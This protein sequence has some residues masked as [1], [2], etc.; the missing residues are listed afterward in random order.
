MQETITYEDALAASTEYFDG[1]EFAAKVFLD[2]YALKDH[3]EGKLLEK[4]PTDMHNRLAKEFARIERKKFKNTTTKPFTDKEIFSFFDHFKK[5]IPGGSPMSGVGNPYQI[6]SLSNCFVVNSPEDSYGGIMKTDEELVQISKR[7]GGVGVDI[8]NLRPQGSLTN[9]AAKTSTGIIPFMCRYSNTIREV[10][11]NGRRGAE[12]ISIS[13]HHPESVIPW[14]EKIDGK[15]FMTKIEDKD[16]GNF[17]ISSK[18][19]NPNKI[20]FAT[21]K[22]DKTKVTGA[23]ISIRLTNEFLEAVEKNKNFEQRWPVD[24]IDPKISKK[25]NARAVW[26]KIIHSAWQTAEPG[27]LFWDN[28]IRES[29][30]DCY[31][32][33]GFQ[34]LSTNPCGELP[35]SKYDSCRLLSLNLLGF[36]KEAFTENAYFDFEEFGRC[37][38]IAQRLMDDL[39]DL[40]IEAVNSIIKKIEKDPENEDIKNRELTLWH[41]ILEACLNGRRTGTGI[42]A[43]GDALAALGLKYG[44]PESIEISAKIYKTLKLNCYRSSVDLA[45]V[46]GPFEVWDH[47]KEKDNAYLLRIKEEDIELYEDMKKYGRRNISLLTTPPAGSISILAQTSSGIEPVFMLSYDRKKKVNP[48]DK[49]AVVEHIDD[50]GDA[51]QSFTIYHPQV[52]V[53]KEVTK[54][55]DLTKSP[56]HGAC[57]NDL[58]WTQRVKLQAEIQKH[59]DNS[60]SSTINLPKEATIEQVAEIYETAWKLGCKGVTIYRDGCRQ[61]VMTKIE[62]K[63]ADSKIDFKQNAPNAVKRPKSL[64]CD[65]HHIKVTKTLDKLRTFDYLV[66]V[67]LMDEKPY[68]VFVMENGT[69]SK[70]YVEGVITKK[71]RG[72]YS[73]SCEDETIIENVIANTTEAEDSL[74]RLTSIALRHGVDMTYVVQQLQKAQG[75]IWSFSKAVARALK[76][77]IKEGTAMTGVS[78]PNCESENMIMSG[79]CPICQDCGHTKCN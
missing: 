23:N 67:G 48:N 41:K 36:V 42:T 44:S 27:L 53:W 50:N 14:D 59:V 72:M 2:K 51:W 16:I 39:V 30:S 24:A 37:C 11:Q 8:S 22:Y 65:I 79:G 19:Y 52:K 32:K 17:N 3:I 74:T 56:W 40:E 15:P 12:M 20:D 60:I 33:E 21:A 5:I 70:K 25:V 69:L 78:C 35:L 49:N 46:L 6:M 68:E 71:K 43:L 10:A 77:Y 75:D 64:K 58:E 45:K 55:E 47:K 63:D 9:N 18:Y 66:I 1:D 29:P 7:R 61:G 26:D 13:I 38:Q 34:T 28:I 31:S 73:V 62:D 76:K 54:E 57:A 4:T